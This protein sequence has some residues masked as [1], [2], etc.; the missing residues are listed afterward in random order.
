MINELNNIKKK[1]NK[2]GLNLNI[3]FKK[4]MHRLFQVMRLDKNVCLTIYFN[5]FNSKMTYLLRDK[6][7]CTLR[8]SFIIGVNVES[9][10]REFSKL[11]R[12]EDPKLFRI[13]GNKK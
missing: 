13:R 12:R 8:D 2:N 6:N 5:A 1:P 3:I 10:R 7:T 11:G 9:N 4:G